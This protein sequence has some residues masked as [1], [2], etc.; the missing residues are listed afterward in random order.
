MGTFIFN[1]VALS[2]LQSI[3]RRDFEHPYSQLALTSFKFVCGLVEKT[4]AD[5]SQVIEQ[6]NLEIFMILELNP[7]SGK[8]NPS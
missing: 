5:I 7:H 4:S 8:Y 6:D 3:L 1:G 2:L